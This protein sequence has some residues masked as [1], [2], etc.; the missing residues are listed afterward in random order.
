[1]AAAF[2][3]GL[4]ITFAHAIFLCV[5][6]TVFS[7]AIFRIS[8]SRGLA[9]AV[10]VLT[11]WHPSFLET[12]ILRDAIYPSQLIL[13]LGL[14]LFAF[15]ISDSSYTRAVFSCLTGIVTGWLWLTREEGLWILPAA[16]LFLTCAAID[17]RKRSLLS[18]RLGIP[19]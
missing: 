13:I 1:L 18:T 3:L 15:F 4:P 17:I 11:L 7:L 2:W 6:L 12:R 14:A 10:F 16:T 19:L 8:N 5:A 9:A